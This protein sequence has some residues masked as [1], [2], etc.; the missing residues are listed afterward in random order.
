MYVD[1]QQCAVPHTGFLFELIL[2]SGFKVVSDNA[3]PLGLHIDSSSTPLS[4][5]EPELNPQVEENEKPLK[6]PVISLYWI[7]AFFHCR[8]LKYPEYTWLRWSRRLALM[9]P[10]HMGGIDVKA[11]WCRYGNAYKDGCCILHS[12]SAFFFLFLL[13]FQIRMYKCGSNNEN[14]WGGC[15]QCNPQFKPY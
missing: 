13:H 4:S 15:K 8:C 5:D 6:R 3:S 7:L 10:N 12:F 9:N 14:R 11:R 1:P 2:L